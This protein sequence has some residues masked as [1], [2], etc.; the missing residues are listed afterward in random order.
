MVEAASGEDK[1]LAAQMAAEFLSE[2][3]SEQQFSAP[4]AG[5][6]MWA[7]LVRIL[8]PIKVGTDGVAGLWA[9][10]RVVVTSS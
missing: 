4:K 8:D 10:C 7:S 1:E 9:S 5:P 2:E 3:L 6:S